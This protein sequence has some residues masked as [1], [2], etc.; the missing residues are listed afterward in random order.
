MTDLSG[1]LAV[2]TGASGGIGTAVC[3]RLRQEG[4]DVWGLDLKPADAQDGT[5]L[6]VDVKDPASIAAAAER[7]AAAG[8]A[9]I[10]VAA[11]GVVEDDV[12]VED[13]D[14][15]LYD[16]VMGV[17]LRG[18]FLVVQAFG[19]HM[20]AKGSGS[21]VTIASMSGNAIVNQPQRQ[22][23][24]N[25]SKAGVTALTKSVA[26]EWGPRGIRVNALSPGYVDTPLNH[27]KAHQH[28]QWKAGT[29]LHRFASTEEVAGAVAFLLG[30]D[31]GY[32][33]GAEL[34]MDGG[35]SLW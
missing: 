24:Y 34:L 28:E 22:A 33:Q 1:R 23:V 29:V 9:D 21:I 15:Q 26:V 30:P 35:Y 16:H 12:A 3:R 17:N 7:V 19:A 5:F 10:L 2:V 4:A 25:A 6:E 27:L 11:A 18:V 8:G 20:L 31:S 32:F 14:V 13:I